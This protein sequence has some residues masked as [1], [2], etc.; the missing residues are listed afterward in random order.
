[1]MVKLFCKL[2]MLVLW[3]FSANHCILSDALADNSNA[4]CHE[5][6]SNKD[7]KST[8]KSHH[9]KCCDSGCCNP[10]LASG[11][12]TFKSDPAALSLT[13]MPI[14]RW[15]SISF[16]YEFL[17]VDSTSEPPRTKP[18]ISTSILLISAISPNGP[19]LL[20]SVA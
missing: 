19:P 11:T 16:D 3:I 4:P 14:I 10:A 9:S 7:S 1:M 12:A 20:V 2:L 17:L 5:H 15:Q 6:S 13:L 18:K 8:P